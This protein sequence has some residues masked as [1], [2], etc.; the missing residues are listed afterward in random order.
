MKFKLHLWKCSACAHE[1]EEYLAVG[2]DHPDTVCPQCGG[3]FKCL[4]TRADRAAKHRAP[5]YIPG[6][7]SMMD[8]KFGTNPNWNRD[9]CK[10]FHE[11][12]SRGDKRKF[13]G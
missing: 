6:F 13:L 7:M 9:E 10:R 12:I 5:N 2:E 1:H 3:E 8:A 11:V 4:G